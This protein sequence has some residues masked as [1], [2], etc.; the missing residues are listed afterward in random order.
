[1][2]RFVATP[3]DVLE[4]ICPELPRNQF[5][6]TGQLAVALELLTVIKTLTEIE[7]LEDP[8]TASVVQTLLSDLGLLDDALELYEALGEVNVTRLVSLPLHEPSLVDSA[9]V[10]ADLTDVSGPSA[11]PRTA[12]QVRR[13][14]ASRLVRRSH[15]PSTE[16]EAPFEEGA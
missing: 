14:G 5:Y 10:G 6:Q 9:D 3:R 7:G 4:R 12:S 1:L 15:R 13:I 16:L 8:T 2:S 11:P